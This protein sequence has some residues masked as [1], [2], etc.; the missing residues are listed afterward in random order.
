M[1]CQLSRTGIAY[2]GPRRTHVAI[3]PPQAIMD[4]HYRACQKMGG[5]ASGIGGRDP[6]LGT[7]LAPSLPD[8]VIAIAASQCYVEM[9]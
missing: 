1:V 7:T 2:T 5:A 9:Y 6:T 4:V 8:G 3:A